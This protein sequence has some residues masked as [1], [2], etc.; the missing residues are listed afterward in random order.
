MLG[1]KELARIVKSQSRYAGIGFSQLAKSAK[2]SKGTLS[3]IWNGHGNPTL[4]T[5]NRIAKCLRF[6]IYTNL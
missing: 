1:Q 2:V 3:K 4:N 6:E 5:V